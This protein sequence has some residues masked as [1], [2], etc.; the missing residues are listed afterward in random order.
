MFSVLKWLLL[1]L[2]CESFVVILFYLC[3]K[4]RTMG[5]GLSTEN[6]LELPP[7]A[8]TPPFVQPSPLFIA[9]RPKAA[10][11]FWFFGDLRCGVLLFM[12]LLVIYIIIKIGKNNC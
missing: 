1:A 5:E 4:N 10:L 6:Y 12:V 8:S 2:K 11:L 9:G 7:F 3:N